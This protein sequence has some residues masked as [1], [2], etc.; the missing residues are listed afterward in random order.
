MDIRSIVH[1]G[2]NKAR[3]NL[4][5]LSGRNRL[6]NF[7]HS[8]I[9]I[10]RF[11]DGLPNQIYAHLIE[12]EKEGFS[13][14]ARSSAEEIRL[15]GDRRQGRIEKTRCPFTRQKTCIETD[16]NLGSTT[17]SM[18]IVTKTINFKLCISLKTWIVSFV[19]S[20]LKQRP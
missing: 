1:D 19:A 16:C 5:D 8:G 15:F 17:T 10:L 7:K 11:V 3:K 13:N 6:L 20:I 4:L 9:K 2:L 18:Q 14:H 12:E